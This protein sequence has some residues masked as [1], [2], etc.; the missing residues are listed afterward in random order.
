MWVRCGADR[1]RRTLAASSSMTAGAVAGGAVHTRKTVSTSSSAGS[2]VS[3]SVRSP[4]ATSTP[5]GRD[6]SASALRVRVRMGAPTSSSSSTTAL[7]VRPVAPTIR[8]GP[9]VE[10]M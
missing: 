7:P 4:M 1:K 5:S 9:S 10:L 8:I 6:A 2:S 3:G